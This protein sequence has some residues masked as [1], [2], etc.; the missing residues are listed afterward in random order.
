MNEYFFS[1]IEV[2]MQ[3]TFQREITIEMENLFR[4]I[5]GDENPLHKDDVYAKQ[6]G[7]WYK[8]HV[9]FGMLTGSL[10]STIVGM[11]LPG[12]YSLIH[13]FDELSFLKPVFAGDIL[14]VT[15]EVT[16][17]EEFLKLICIKAVIRNQEYIIVSRA[18][19]KVLVTK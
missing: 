8:K 13:S 14:T 7:E 12:K 6:C 15:G 19:I 18:R 17:K 10:Y 9:A 16:S 1:D 2:G 3:E 4:Y 11:Y 5:T